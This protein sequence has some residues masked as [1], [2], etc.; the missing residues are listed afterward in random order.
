MVRTVISDEEAKFFHENGYLILRNVLAEPELSRVQAAMDELMRYGSETVRDHPDYMYGRGHKTG[1][2]VLQRI[3]YVIDKKDEMK[4]LLGHPFILNTV[5]KLMGPDLIPTWDSMVLKLPG[6]GIVIPWHRDAGTEHVGD[7]PI[8]NVDFY[9]DPADY[10]TCVWVIPGSH[11]WSKEQTAAWLQ[12]HAKDHTRADFEA[13][14]AVPA[15]MSP[16]DVLLHNILVLHGSPENASEKLRRVVYYE[17]RTA[18]VEEKLGPHTP[19][20]IPHKQ[21][22]LLACLERRRQADYI[23]ADEVPYVYHP[24]APWNQV[25]LAPGEELPTY[26]YPH[27]EFWRAA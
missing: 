21:K 15:L 17:F 11:L 10:D 7:T 23:P 26:R 14:G 24:P 19:E 1:Q 8:F 12:E 6:E 27:G 3:E 20:Y 13:S 16:G 25:Q 18:H 4:V 22:V 9:L 2:P 5:E